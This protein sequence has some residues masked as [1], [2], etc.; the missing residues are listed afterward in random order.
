MFKKLILVLLLI[1]VSIATGYFLCKN[2]ILFQNNDAVIKIGVMLPLTGE[3]SQWGNDAKNAIELAVEEI[4]KKNTKYK[5]K[6]I[7]ENDETDTKK[8][9][10]VFNKLVDIDNV[11]YCMVD[12]ISSNVLAIAPI[13]NEKKVIIISPGASNPKIT[14]AGDYVF[15]NWPS[16]ALQGEV[17]ANVASESLKWLKIAIL[18]INNDYGAGLSDAFTKNLS[19]TSKVVAN[20]SYDKG[21]Q[22][23]RTQ[24]LKIKES[25]PDGIYVLAYPEELPLIFKQAKE[26]SLNKTFLGTETFESQQLI[27]SVGVIADG[28]IYTFPQAPNSAN[29]VATDFRKS[30][31]TKFEKPWGTPGDAAYDAVYMMVNA[32]EANG[33]STEKVKKQ[34]YGIKNFEGASGVITI[35]KNGDAVKTFEL[36][37]IK[38]GQFVKYE[39]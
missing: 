38:G 22:D 5:Y 37:I 21:T 27:D 11:K 2:K 8:A 7:Y 16:D 32:I 12:M 30:Y 31:L 29:K 36:K 18:K 34:L 35:D 9:V 26:L 6:F 13:A 17:D 23:F 28:A 3:G 14:D 24:L 15:R 20:E 4:S 19:A 33:D 10:T 39:F 1:T 25:N